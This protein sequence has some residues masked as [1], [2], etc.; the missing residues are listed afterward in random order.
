M[1]H[2]QNADRRLPSSNLV[3]HYLSTVGLADWVPDAQEVGEFAH[4]GMVGAHKTKIMQRDRAV[5]ARIS[6]SVLDHIWTGVLLERCWL[7]L[8][9]GASFSDI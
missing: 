4:G 7:M 9:G 5:Y 1:V 6:T 8:F 2:R 3:G